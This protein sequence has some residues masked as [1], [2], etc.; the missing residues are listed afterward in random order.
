MGLKVRAWAFVVGVSVVVVVVVGGSADFFTRRSPRVVVCFG[1]LRRK[2]PR[3]PRQ[4]T[5][6][7]DLGAVI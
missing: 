7:C 1:R 2:R 6:A 4:R 5:R 3:V